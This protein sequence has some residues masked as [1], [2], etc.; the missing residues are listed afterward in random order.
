MKNG[1]QHDSKKKSS[2]ELK[3]GRKDKKKAGGE[4]KNGQ[5]HDSKKK[6]SGE[7][8]NGRKDSK[9][10]APQ[11]GDDD[12]EDDA[13]VAKARKL[14]EEAE[15]NLN[16]LMLK[17]EAAKDEKERRALEEKRAKETASKIQ[18]ATKGAEK[19]GLEEVKTFRVFYAG[20]GEETSSE[21]DFAMLCEEI[22]DLCQDEDSRHEQDFETNIRTRQV[23]CKTGWSA[24]TL[25]KAVE[26]YNEKHPKLLDTKEVS[27][28]GMTR[29]VVFIKSTFRGTKF[30]N[31]F[32]QRMMEKNKI[33]DAVFVSEQAINTRRSNTPGSNFFFEVDQA[34]LQRIK[35]KDDLNWNFKLKFHDFENFRVHLANEARDMT[36]RGRGPSRDRDR[37]ADRVS[38]LCRDSE[39]GPSRD[40]VSELSRD[41]E[42][43]HDR[44]RDR[45]GRDGSRGRG[46][47]GGKGK[48]RSRSR[49]DERGASS[50]KGKRKG[51]KRFRELTVD[52]KQLLR[53]TA[54]ALFYTFK[55]S[56]VTD[57]SG[58]VSN[59]I[60]AANTYVTS[61]GIQEND[62]AVEL[63][64]AAMYV[65]QAHYA[66]AA[67]VL[68]MRSFARASGLSTHRSSSFRQLTRR[69]AGR[70]RELFSHL[71]DTNGLLEKVEA[72]DRAFI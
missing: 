25:R 46:K 61:I 12:V 56:E 42:A 49:N 60:L 53:N 50:E 44:D 20:A 9:K 51:S 15:A 8:K 69:M 66:P 39:A 6:S 70:A 18:L 41:R 57:Q 54:E 19:L 2:G 37:E 35:D 68:S 43:G 29:L 10:V 62:G 24:D 64:T 34:M 26:N 21:L 48:G 7:L 31:V 3:N 27:V 72:L 33:L 28:S 59:A 55:L 65:L 45:R 16:E 58:L 32:F 5:Q 40:R 23:K 63:A 38:E 22:N 36:V 4:L 67:Q 14:R 13:G 52:E 1:P 11:Q 47:N 30:P 17:L 71:G